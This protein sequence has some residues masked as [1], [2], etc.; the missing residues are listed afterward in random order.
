MNPMLV[1]KKK[2]LLEKTKE[3]RGE[4]WAT[5]KKSDPYGLLTRIP[6]KRKTMEEI[7]II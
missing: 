2:D 6:R 4:I 5:T 3:K 7:K 1:L